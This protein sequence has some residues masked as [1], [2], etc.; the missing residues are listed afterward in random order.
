MKEH[1]TF[2][3]F[4]NAWDKIKELPECEYKI[5]MTES[6]M[7]ERGYSEPQIERMKTKG[8][9]EIPEDRE[10]FDNWFENFLAKRNYPHGNNPP[11]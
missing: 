1:L 7:R 10:K 4:K 6:E 2:A 5:W 9:L 8:E 11:H 3:K